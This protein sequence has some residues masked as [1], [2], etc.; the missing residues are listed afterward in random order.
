MNY[1]VLPL[2]NLVF[3][4]SLDSAMKKYLRNLSIMVVHS[5]L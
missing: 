3:S 5:E 1:A 2:A 4:V